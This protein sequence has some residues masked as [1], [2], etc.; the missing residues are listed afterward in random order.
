MPS[1]DFYQYSCGGV[2]DDPFL[3]PESHQLLAENLIKG[4]AMCCKYY[5]V[6][7]QTVCISCV[8]TVHTSL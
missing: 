6:I 4:E 8:C 7:F 3:D 5:V 1:Q 2:E